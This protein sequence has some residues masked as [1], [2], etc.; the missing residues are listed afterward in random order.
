[1]VQA[2]AEFYLF[3]EHYFENIVD[4]ELLSLFGCFFV[5]FLFR[6]SLDCLLGMDNSEVHFVGIP[7]VD[8]IPAADYSL[9][10][11]CILADCIL[12]AA[13]YSPAVGYSLAGYTPVVNILDYIADCSFDWIP[14]HSLDYSPADYSFG[15]NFDYS[16][17]CSLDCWFGHISADFSPDSKL[18]C[19]LA[20][21]FHFR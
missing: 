10:A 14:A 3:I 20:H 4:L 18:S 11:D 15:C 13:G 6:C 2:C 7:V 21:T 9:A 5:G 16:P 19:S 1:M 12:A 17:D 8:C